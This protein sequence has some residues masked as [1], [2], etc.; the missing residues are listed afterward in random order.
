MVLIVSLLFV[1]GHLVFRN[2]KYAINIKEKVVGVMPLGMLVAGLVAGG[3]YICSK[4]NYLCTLQIPLK[5]EWG[6]TNGLAASSTAYHNIDAKQTVLINGAPFYLE[7]GLFPYGDTVSVSVEAISDFSDR[8][9]LRFYQDT[10]CDGCVEIWVENQGVADAT[11]CQFRL[12]DRQGELK[13]HFFS[14]TLSTTVS[15]VPAGARLCLFS[16]N[17]EEMLKTQYEEIPLEMSVEAVFSSGDYQGK[18]T[19]SLPVDAM[20]S[21]R[22]VTIENIYPQQR[23][24]QLVSMHQSAQWTSDLNYRYDKMN[25]GGFYCEQTMLLK[26]QVVV[27]NFWGG[28]TELTP[29]VFIYEVP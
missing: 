14:E 29:V 25:I 6:Y 12:F 16:L 22:G 17:S 27:N 2:L 15:S 7:T 28:K 13:E 18:M 1:I 9:Y 24:G 5:Y 8:P 11:N 10:I 4:P 20:L 21:M 23:D 3:L 19:K 26:I